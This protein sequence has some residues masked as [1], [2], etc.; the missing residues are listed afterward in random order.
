MQRALMTATFA[1]LAAGL[2]LTVWGIKEAS[3][4]KYQGAEKF[5]AGFLI[6]HGSILPLKAAELTY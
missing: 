3:E 4:G 2:G 5:M 6:A 1:M